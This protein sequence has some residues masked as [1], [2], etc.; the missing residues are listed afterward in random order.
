MT[1]RRWLSIH[2]L[3]RD[4]RVNRVLEVKDMQGREALAYWTGQIWAKAPVR[5]VAKA[6]NWGHRPDYWREQISPEEAVEK[7]T[8]AQRRVMLCLRPSTFG[9]EWPGAPIT[10]LDSCVALWRRDF[11]ESND[12]GGMAATFSGRTLRVR[13]NDRGRELLMHVQKGR[14]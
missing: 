1:R 2:D 10:S 5:K 12:I 4:Q 13:L 3:P 11:L 9:Y 8:K 6:L 14:Q 7:L